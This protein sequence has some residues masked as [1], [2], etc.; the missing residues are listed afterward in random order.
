MNYKSIIMNDLANGIGLRTTLFV[1]GCTFACDGCFN[2][3]IWDFNKGKPFTEE[4]IDNIIELCSGSNIRGLSILG[5]EPLHDKNVNDIYELVETFKNYL[6]DKSIWLWT[7]YKYE[8]IYM[9]DKVIES[10]YIDMKEIK[11]QLVLECIDVLIDGKFEKDNKDLSLRF[12][13]SSNQRIID[14]QNSL[15]QRKIIE[16]EEY[17]G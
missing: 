2:F 1:T 17:Y 10:G 6:P 12:R 16:L 9:L 3:D 11:R 8:D 5:G 15:K 14:V 13:G 4:T 7:G